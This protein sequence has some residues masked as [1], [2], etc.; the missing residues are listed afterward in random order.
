MTEY[1]YDELTFSDVYKD[2]TGVRPGYDHPFFV[3]DDPDEKQRLWDRELRAVQNA[4]E[5]DW[6]N[7]QAAINDFED[8]ISMNMSRGAPTRDDAIRWIIQ[9]YVDD[10]SAVQGR[11]I[12]GDS[13]LVSMFCFV[14]GLPYEYESIVKNA[15]V[16]GI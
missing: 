2:A 10:D 15:L 11:D 1:T 12:S 7:E 16:K 9:A 3:T 13:D 4:I 5:E 8:Q 6:G 14:Y